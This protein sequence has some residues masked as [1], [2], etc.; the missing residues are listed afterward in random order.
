[1]AEKTH[2]PEWP[3][4]CWVGCVDSTHSLR[5]TSS[6]V[7]YKKTKIMRHQ[8]EKGMIG[9]AI[10]HNAQLWQTDGHGERSS[11]ENIHWKW[12]IFHYS[13]HEPIFN[14]DNYSARRQWC[15]QGKLKRKLADI[16]QQRQQV[17]YVRESREM[18]ERNKHKWQW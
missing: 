17:K 18:Y 12:C 14:D 13:L 5:Q 15:R 11:R 4:V 2:P 1:M 6:Y 8:V 10:S 9:S 3:A 7:S 16:L